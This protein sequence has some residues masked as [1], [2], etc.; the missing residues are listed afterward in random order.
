MTR[1]LALDIATTVG[2]A[3]DGPE[4]WKPLT[5]AVRFAASGDDYGRAYA[6]LDQ[7]LFEFIG[8]HRPDVLAFEA[9]LI[10]GGRT[11]TT[12]RTNAHT[13]RLLFGLA[14]VAEMVGSRAGLPVYECHIQTVRR[15]FV[16]NGRAQKPEVM[17]RCRALGW[18]VATNDAADAA[19][20]WDF[21]KSRFQPSAAHRGTPMFAG[22][23]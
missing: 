3:V 22:A 1:V 12:R 8:L 19:A 14:A 2:F 21:V 10:V 18:E 23:Q 7:W 11:G 20:I 4:E 6:G 15:H 5:G 9:P 16:G 13:V 17:A